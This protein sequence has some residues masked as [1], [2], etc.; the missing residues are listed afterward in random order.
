MRK[1]PITIK[2]FGERAILVEWPNQVEESILQDILRFT[3][4][5]EELG[6]SGWELVPAYNSVTMVYNLG[7]LDF[8]ETKQTVLDLSLIHI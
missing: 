5:F 2:P 1:Y 3:T 7:I 6:I 4:A 8:E